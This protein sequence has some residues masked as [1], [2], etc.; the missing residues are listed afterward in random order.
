M[1]VAVAETG[2]E[3]FSNADKDAKIYTRD[4]LEKMRKHFTHKKVLK[5]IGSIC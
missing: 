2:Y 4:V 3:G 1:I 5:V